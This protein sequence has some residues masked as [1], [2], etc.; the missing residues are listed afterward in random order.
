MSKPDSAAE[1]HDVP[2]MQPLITPRLAE[3]NGHDSS[4]SDG[5][6]DSR[7]PHSD[8]SLMELDDSDAE[9]DECDTAKAN[10]NSSPRASERNRQVHHWRS[11]PPL[12]PQRVAT[13][14][15]TVSGATRLSLEVTALFWEAVFEI[16]SE[17]TSSGLWLGSTAWEEA[18]SITLACAS[19]LSP[20]SS[21]NPRIVS[22]IV[23]SSTAAGYSVVNQSFSAAESLLEG[24]FTL[25]TKAVNMGLHAAGEYVRFIDAIFGSTD[26]SRVLASFVHMCRREAV[27]KNPEIRAL[28]KEHGVLGFISQVVKTVIALACLQVV[29][30][31]RPR[32]YKLELVYT[33]VGSKTE[34]CARKFVDGNGK[35]I[36]S[37]ASARTP[38]HR[39]KA[40]TPW[41]ISPHLPPANAASTVHEQLHSLSPTA[42]LPDIANMQVHM[43]AHPFV[44]PDHGQAT[45]HKR[46]PAVFSEGSIDADAE[47]DVYYALSDQEVSHRDPEWDQRLMEAL[48]SLSIHTE[49]QNAHAAPA[50][51]SA[52][53]AA[54]DKYSDSEGDDDIACDRQHSQ[55]RKERKMST[56][57]LWNK[58]SFGRLSTAEATAQAQPGI[59]EDSNSSNDIDTSASSDSSSS[60]FTFMSLQK[61][62]D[63]PAFE[64]APASL[65][66]SPQFAATPDIYIVP[67]Q[68]HRASTAVDYYAQP[69]SEQDGVLLAGGAQDQPAID[70]QQQ[71]QQ[72]QGQQQQGQHQMADGTPELSIAS[73]FPLPMPDAS[74]FP[75]A[76]SGSKWLQQEFPR[77]PLLFNLARFISIASSAYGRS[78]MKVLGLDHGVIDARAL[79]EDFGDF[80]V[81]AES[82]SGYSNRVSQSP[83]ARPADSTSASPGL[84]ATR[85]GNEGSTNNTNSP[86]AS[87]CLA[88]EPSMTKL[89]RAQPMSSYHTHSAYNPSRPGSQRQY[90]RRHFRS[91]QPGT[92]GGHRSIGRRPP[93]RRNHHRRRPITEHPNHFCFSQHTGIPL[94]DLL[95]SSY[96]PPIV[97]GVTKSA[98]VRASAVERRLRHKRSSSHANGPAGKKSR[99]SSASSNTNPRQPKQD[100][101]VDTPD[102][103]ENG[104]AT[105]PKGWVSSIPIVGTIYQ[106][107][108]SPMDALS[109][110]PVIP[111]MV[112]RMLRKPSVVELTKEKPAYKQSKQKQ[113]RS[114][115]KDKKPAGP[116]AEP[117]SSQV[118]RFDKIRQRLVYRNPSIHVLVH[119]IAVD[120][121]T[122]S[123]VLACRG[124]LG[125]SDLFIDMICEYETIRLP[126]HPATEGQSEYRVH[127]GMWHSALL[128]AD[129]SSEVF[130]EVAEAL[131]LYPE[132]GLVVTGHSLGGG[133]GS[134]LTLL[135]SQPTFMHD[136]GASSPANADMTPM[137]P[138]SSAGSIRRFVTSEL[139]GLVSPRP[140]HCFNFGSPCSTNAALSHYCRGLVTSVVNT[141]DFVSFLSVGSCV[142]ILNISAVLGRERG[143]AEKVVR[144][145][146]SSQRSKLSR[147]FRLFDF[148]FSK[149]RAYS[150]DDDDDDD[151]DD[152]D[153]EDEGMGRDRNNEEIQ[154]GEANDAASEADA[155]TGARKRQQQK[156]SANGSYWWSRKTTQSHVRTNKASTPSPDPDS[157]SMHSSASSSDSSKRPNGKKN[158][159]DW[160]WSLIKTLRANMDSEKLYPPGDVF[161]LA[162]PG[163]EEASDRQFPL[164]D[165]SA[166]ATDGA[167]GNGNG[168][169]NGNGNG[170]GNGKGN[171]DGEPKAKAHS[172]DNTKETLPVGLFYCPDVAERFSELRFTRN[173]IIH[174]LPTT[175]ERKISALIHDT[176]YN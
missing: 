43:E 88:R 102:N 35:P 131:R 54:G 56:K 74:A 162:S 164:M 18:K 168:N 21:L 29:N 92:P 52:A 155:S 65:I 30:H 101:A 143:V 73:N 120:H 40:S 17:S 136:E 146:L 166:S 75:P 46:L 98:S 15:S 129:Q 51:T 95:F 7:Y 141:D 172:G 121:A 126:N 150:F 36:P 138:G 84:T 91:M 3:D 83:R 128:L 140:I 67:V 60:P 33:N 31:G 127:S 34:F 119:Y 63:F 20:L 70:Q 64:S 2:S 149:L 23:S 48:R 107:M 82:D 171:S 69:P 147:K 71:G 159:D 94:G 1:L 134:L 89:P 156:Q 152:G 72:Q 41:A 44:Q 61:G 81:R 99:S 66:S 10:D 62:R 79:I 4:D 125:I 105:E 112:S 49:R 114:P 8:D 108:P 100:A 57:S 14:V 59:G 80:E 163:D 5:S 77:K 104:K 174:H 145:F 47:D 28:L 148:D 58:L 165:D 22:R 42:Q 132:Y 55:A 115:P 13:L 118:R 24:G 6:V 26:T 45:S 173:M 151:N 87:P 142:D 161:I 25:Y 113:R 124:T 12:L 116:P 9:P 153:Y 175:Y 157:A 93:V 110:V 176:L 169:S 130:K 139:F 19:F 32:S 154:D 117:S 144:R 158:L 109:S 133:V 76:L 111:G 86:H 38:E 122:R 123:V 39:S 135:W 27:E 137:T 96:V 85:P 167:T 50:S 90:E 103:A 106:S 78:F 37:K 16:I 68:K 170:N 97:P 11:Q 160:Y 53:N